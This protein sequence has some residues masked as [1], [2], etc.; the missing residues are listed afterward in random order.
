MTQAGVRRSEV[1]RIRDKGF[2]RVTE[3][4]NG[5]VTHSA[6]CGR[7]W[8]AESGQEKT[9]LLLGTGLGGKDLGSG[10][11]GQAPKGR[12]LQPCRNWKTVGESDEGTESTSTTLQ[13]G[14]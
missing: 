3:S 6:S 2:I 7:T 14:G 1:H 10:K 4:S 5:S 13:N 12:A 9:G 11:V 8:V